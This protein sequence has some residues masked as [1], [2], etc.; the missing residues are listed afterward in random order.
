MYLIRKNNNCYLYW[1][2]VVQ[3]QQSKHIQMYAYMHMHIYNSLSYDAFGFIRTENKS[4]KD[5]I[6]VLFSQKHLLALTCFDNNIY[7]SQVRNI[8]KCI[9]SKSSVHHMDTNSNF[10]ID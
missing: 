5:R 9:H 6:I 2:M 10:L 7:F 4:V 8:L 3:L 1:P